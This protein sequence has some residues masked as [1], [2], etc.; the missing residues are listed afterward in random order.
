MV[1]H[2]EQPSF[3]LELFLPQAPVLD[4]ATAQIARAI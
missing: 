1:Q 3:R 4:E 2:A